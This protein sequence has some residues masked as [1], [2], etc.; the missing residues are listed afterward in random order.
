MV[1]KG[2]KLAMSVT[3]PTATT[4][5]NYNPEEEVET[6]ECTGAEGHHPEASPSTEQN[7]EPTLH[8]ES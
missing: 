2:L 8:H 5:D 4:L 1:M 7:D 3:E 6:E